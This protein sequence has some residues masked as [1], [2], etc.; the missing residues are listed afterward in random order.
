MKAGL[1]R[2]RAQ[3]QQRVAT[4]GDNGERTY[5]WVTLATVWARLEALGGNEREY[6]DQ[7]GAVGQYKIT[8][9]YYDIDHDNR[10]VI[11]SRNFGIS[12]VVHDDR[13][14]VMTTVTAYEEEE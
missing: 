3:I 10:I 2:D 9:R 1:L 7:T 6:G 4:I 8:M 13:R 5:S 12:S 11:D 14:S